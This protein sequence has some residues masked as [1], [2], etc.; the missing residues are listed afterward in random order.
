MILRQTRCKAQGLRHSLERACCQKRREGTEA[1][2]KAILQ[3]RKTDSFLLSFAK[4]TKTIVKTYMRPWDNPMFQTSI[5]T[6]REFK[7]F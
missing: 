4:P 2:L 1:M 7:K 3:I 5:E 6:V